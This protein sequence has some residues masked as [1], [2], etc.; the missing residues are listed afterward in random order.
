MY[1]LFLLIHS[2]LR[3]LVLLAAIYAAV[4]A[5]R[6]LSAKKPFR[7]GDERLNRAFVG[8]VDL[9]FMVGLALYLFL[10]PI[11]QG[12]FAN[13]KAAMRSAPL[14]FFAIEHITAMLIALALAHVGRARLRRAGDDAKR[15]RNALLS[16]AGFL[17]IALI[18]MPWPMLKHGR[19]LL[20][21]A[22]V[23][24]GAAGDTRA[25]PELYQKRCAACHGQGGRGDGPAAAA[26]QPRPRDFADPSWQS[27]VSD[28]QL[29]S[30][31][32]QGGSARQLSASMP[33]HP[34]LRAEQVDA[35]IRF[36]RASAVR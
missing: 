26:M 1:A 22:L 35:L 17:V 6:A 16:S 31:I 23:T 28:E 4:Q 30:V 20:R 32:R 8:L 33:A 21:T 3:W 36:V 27:S 24:E 7:S 15:Q 2:W 14:R 25:A 11:V 12:A 19:P 29:R 5:A 34:D 13:M 9:Q 10:S 18:G